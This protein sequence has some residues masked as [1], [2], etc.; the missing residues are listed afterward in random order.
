M[1]PILLTLAIL[2]GGDVASTQVVL[3]QGGRELN[4]FVPQGPTKNLLAGSAA[5]AA[6]IYLLHKLSAKHPKVAK[7]LGVIAIGVEGWAVAHNVG[8]IRK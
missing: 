7:T 8:Q 6:D 4:P 1:N 3:Q 2:H 5:S